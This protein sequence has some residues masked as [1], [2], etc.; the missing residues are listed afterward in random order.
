MYCY[1]VKTTCTVLGF[2][3]TLGFPL[4]SPTPYTNSVAKG[5]LEII[6]GGREVSD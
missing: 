3:V 2:A 6:Y 5:C 4:A 1:S